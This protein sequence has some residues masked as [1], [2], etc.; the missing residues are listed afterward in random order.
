MEIYRDNDII[1]LIPMQRQ[2]RWGIGLQV[3]YSNLSGLYI[4][5]GVSYNLFTW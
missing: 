3:G 5:A 2:K 4:G 1:T